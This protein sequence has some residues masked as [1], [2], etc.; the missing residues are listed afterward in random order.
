MCR[1]LQSQVSRARD[2][3]GVRHERSGCWN[4]DICVF[5]VYPNE[6]SLNILPAI[7]ANSSFDADAYC[8]DRDK[9]TRGIC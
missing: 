6:Y 9:I 3:N 4:G 7:C 2:S 1:N 8:F 5:S